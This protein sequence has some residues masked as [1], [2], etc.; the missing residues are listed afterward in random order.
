MKF[1]HLLFAAALATSFGCAAWAEPV[2]LGLTVQVSTTVTLGKNVLEYSNA[3]AKASGGE[4]GIEIFPDAK[5]F[6]DFEVPK[7]VSG[8]AI[9]M[10][11]AQLG[12]YAKDVPAVEIFQQPFLFDSDE[13]TRAATRPDS[14]IRKLIDAQIL[15]KT[16][17]R[18]LWWQPYGATVVMSKTAPIPNPQ[19]MQ[20][21]V[22]RSIDP[23]AAEFVQ[24][25][26]GKPEVIPG[27]KMLDAL[28]TGKVDSVMT[29]VSG[30][31]VRNLWQETQHVTRLRQSVIMFLVIINET[32]WQGLSQPQRELML[33][34]A[35]KAEAAYWND[36]AAEELAAYR[37]SAEK[38]MTVTEITNEDL[39]DWRVCSSDLVERFVEKL[40]DTA[41][42]LMTAYGQLR[43]ES[44]C[45]TGRA[46]S[47]LR[48]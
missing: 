28:K 24:L 37:F 38:G 40:G 36:F 2:K 1:A 20:N 11:V 17:A 35:R 43:A 29:G 7:A 12:L 33:A 27:S 30:V 6:G 26:G 32:V 42:R 10:G 34:E 31:I 15:E 19:A 39:A 22:V 45:K 9:E 13:L 16:G 44:C 47:A 3:M 41:D 21:R 25:C 46:E 48:R 14:E 4:I 8:G 23:V 18:V 5:R